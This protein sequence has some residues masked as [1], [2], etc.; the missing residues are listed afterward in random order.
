MVGPGASVAL[1]GVEAPLV[2]A[3]VAERRA[4]L[5]ALPAGAPPGPMVRS[6]DG[7]IEVDATL[8]TRMGRARVMLA[9]DVAAALGVGG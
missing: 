8:P 7:R 2:E 4:T 6:A 5:Q 9:E 3:L 1:P